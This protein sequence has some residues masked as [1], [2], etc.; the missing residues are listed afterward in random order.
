MI[1]GV[2]ANSSAG[3]SSAIGQ[4]SS[5]RIRTKRLAK[6]AFAR[7]AQRLPVR[8]VSVATLPLCA[9]RSSHAFP[10]AMSEKTCHLRPIVSPSR[11]TRGFA[12][13]TVV[14]GSRLG[15]SRRVDGENEVSC[16][17]PV[18]RSEFWNFR[19]KRKFAGFWNACFAK[20]TCFAGSL[21]IQT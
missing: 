3:G 1:V 6:S 13:A 10:M 5:L 9:E 21:A 7:G 12:K 19:Q 11:K 14:D 8:E 17:T 15:G 4:V 2:E 20:S 18:A 16:E